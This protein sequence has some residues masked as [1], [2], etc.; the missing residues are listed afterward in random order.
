MRTISYGIPL[1]VIGVLAALPFRRVPE[2]VTAA[3][4]AQSQPL[5]PPPAM[6]E[7]TDPQPS[8]WLPPPQIEPAPAP[9][10]P[11]LP[12]LPGTYESVAVPLETPSVITERYS[13][14]DERLF[15]G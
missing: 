7:V 5:N 12:D 13:A 10:Q 2:E 3:T 11:A 8:V 1:L 14:V 9:A 4:V 15:G 6:I